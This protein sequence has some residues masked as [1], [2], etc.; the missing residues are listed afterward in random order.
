MLRIESKLI[1]LDVCQRLNRTI[2]LTCFG[3]LL[4]GLLLALAL[5]IHAQINP[6]AGDPLFSLPVL[7]LDA[8]SKSD[9]TPAGSGIKA[10]AGA[11]FTYVPTMAFK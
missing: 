10:P 8:T 3:G 4:P 5:P 6:Y 9:P 7:V 1:H 2:Q 11:N